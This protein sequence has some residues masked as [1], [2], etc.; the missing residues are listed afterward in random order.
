MYI[1]ENWL[2][3]DKHYSLELCFSIEKQ[4]ET[5]FAWG[6]FSIARLNLR[7]TTV[8]SAVITDTRDAH[9]FLPIPRNYPRSVSVCLPPPACHLGH[10]WRTET[11]PFL[12]FNGDT[13]RQRAH[14][15][16][17]GSPTAPVTAPTAPVTAPTSVGH[18]WHGLRHG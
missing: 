11:N 6:M 14:S 16:S 12:V 4:P 5:V 3:I 17:A 10:D 13:V 7:D 18:G 15:G 8:D 2:G 9:S 1:T